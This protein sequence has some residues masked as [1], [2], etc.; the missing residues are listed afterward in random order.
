MDN[1]KR[2]LGRKYI[3][4][5]VITMVRRGMNFLELDKE[6]MAQEARDLIEG[7]SSKDGTLDKGR[8]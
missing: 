7:A 8:T 4:L 6:I 1:T 3:K 5:K 2:E